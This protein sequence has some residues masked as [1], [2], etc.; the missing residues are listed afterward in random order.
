MLG[1]SG[2]SIKYDDVTLRDRMAYDGLQDIFTDQPKGKVTK[3]ANSGDRFVSC[4]EQDAFA[5]AS[6]Q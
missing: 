3:S 1:K 6:H 4:E 2:Q 5:D